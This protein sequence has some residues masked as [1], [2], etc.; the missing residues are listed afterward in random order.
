MNVPVKCKTPFQQNMSWC[1]LVSKSLLFQK[2]WGRMLKQVEW[3]SETWWNPCYL[4]EPW[5]MHSIGNWVFS[6]QPFAENSITRVCQPDLIKLK[7]NW[8]LN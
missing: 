2:F 8:N 3:I 5:T 4:V 1:Y 7:N 6:S